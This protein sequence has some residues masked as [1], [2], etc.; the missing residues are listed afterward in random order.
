MSIDIRSGGLVAVDTDALRDAAGRYAVERAELEEVRRMLRTEAARLADLVDPTGDGAPGRVE[1]IAGG[2]DAAAATAGDLAERLRL[3][4]AVYEIVESRAARAAALA[5]GDVATA[6]QLDARLRLLEAEDPAAAQRADTAEGEWRRR[7]GDAIASSLPG[8]G[9]FGMTLLDHVLFASLL[10][11]GLG[12][13]GAGRAPSVE[14]LRGPVQPIGIRQVGAARRASAPSSLAGAVGRIPSG[15]SGAR[16]RVER[17]AMPD[18]TRRFALYVAGTRSTAFGGADPW[19]MRSNREL[20]TGSRSASYDATLSAL[21]AAGA[22]RGDVLYVVG[23]S[24]G[25]MIADRVALEGGYDTRLLVTVGSPTEAAAGPDTLSVQLRHSDDPVASLVHGGSEGSVGAPGS[26]VVE[27]VADPALGVQDL[28]LAAHHLDAYVETAR[29]ADVS[30]D[31]RAGGVRDVLGELR[32]AASV[33]V[34]EYDA[35]R[36]G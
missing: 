1:L 36:A 16:V 19:D 13:A 17:Y 2:V 29:Q 20:Y 30:P 18:G 35:E 22:R 5:A 31:P 23:H 4:A 12:V 14:P 6:E 25:G 21:R 3:L 15:D 8:A 34:T 24:Q 33:V 9:W 32:S 11:A 26:L 28:D 27:R 10:S 7:T